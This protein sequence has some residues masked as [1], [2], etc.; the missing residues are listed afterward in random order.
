MTP[1][2]MTTATP[3]LTVD[4]PF[5]GSG[6]RRARLGAVGP[7]LLRPRTA[8]RQGG[9][10]N[11]DLLAVLERMLAHPLP[12]D[13]DAV[14]RPE[15]LNDEAARG[16]HDYGVA[17][18]NARPRNLQVIVV[19]PAQVVRRRKPVLLHRS[20]HLDQQ[21]RRRQQERVLLR[22]GRGLWSRR[23]CVQDRGVD[24]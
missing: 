22:A 20:I 10:A 3:S 21:R 23:G 5:T 14:L 2:G 13:E 11:H 17:P 12:I 4:S 6:L 7:R 9:I 24:L 8:E 18:R 15:V 19:R 16:R 1:D